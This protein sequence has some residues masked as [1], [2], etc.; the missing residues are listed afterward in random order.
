MRPHR[1]LSAP[2]LA[3]LGLFGVL[4]A[5]AMFLAPL[6]ALHAHFGLFVSFMLGMTPVLLGLGLYIWA[7]AQLKNGVQNGIWTEDQLAPLRR[8]TL[9]PFLTATM[10]ALLAEFLVLTLFNMSSHT[11]HALRAWGWSAY[12]FL[13]YIQQLQMATKRPTVN[14]ST[15][16]RI[17]WRTRP[18]IQSE[19][20]GER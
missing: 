20:W 16:P 7:V 6:P 2:Q 10:F 14:V 9:S 17:D 12:L 19:H 15:A 13:M 5:E 4:I 18:P 1:N 8:I 11:H 3:S